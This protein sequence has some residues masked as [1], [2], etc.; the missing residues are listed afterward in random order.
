MN[1]KTFS[2]Y[3]FKLMWRYNLEVP[4]SWDKMIFFKGIYGKVQ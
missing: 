4:E 1:V 2:S 3:Y